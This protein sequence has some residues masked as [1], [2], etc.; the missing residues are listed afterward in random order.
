[1]GQA[2]RRR[3]ILPPA[4]RAPQARETTL[5]TRSWRARVAVGALLRELRVVGARGDAVSATVGRLRLD[6]RPLPHSSRGSPHPEIEAHDVDAL[7]RALGDVGPEELET[8]LRVVRR[9]RSLAGAA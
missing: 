7:L 9:V 3:A 1:M 6:E 2:E 5:A 4:L 8:A